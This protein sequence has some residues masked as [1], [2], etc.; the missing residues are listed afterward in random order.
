MEQTKH[1][2]LKKPAPEDFYDVADQ[3]ANMDAIDAALKAQEDELAHKAG[4]DET[5]KVPEEQLPKLSTLEL[6]ETDTTAYRGDRG[7]LAYEHLM[8]GTKHITTEERSRWNHYPTAFTLATSA[9]SANSTYSDY[10]Y[11]A[12]ISISGLTTA[13][14]VNI[15]FDGLSYT[16]A[17]DSGVAGF[18][19]TAAEVVY[20]YATEKPASNLTGNYVVTKGV[21]A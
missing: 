17:N 5:G 16:V 6:G 2:G 13:D 1:Y 14:S 15:Y 12:S 18:T 3:N 8:D 20:I 19:E 7:K 21:S 10:G 9:W 4:L 11:R